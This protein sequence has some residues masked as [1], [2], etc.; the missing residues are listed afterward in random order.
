MK[1]FSTGSAAAVLLGI[2][3]LM[4]APAA[5]AQL[6]L[7]TCIMLSQECSQGNQQACVYYARGCKGKS[8]MGSISIDAFPA[9][10]NHK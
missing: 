10:L 2:G 7:D 9:E 3:A 1:I 8:S 4:H 6:P 5:S